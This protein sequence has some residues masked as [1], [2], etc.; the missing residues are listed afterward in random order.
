MVD[1]I[2]DDNAFIEISKYCEKL[3]LTVPTYISKELNEQYIEPITDETRQM[4]V[5]FDLVTSLV[6]EI[7]TNG[8]I[9]KDAENHLTVE[10]LDKEGH[11]VESTMDVVFILQDKDSEDGPGLMLF[12]FTKEEV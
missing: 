2:E 7:Q 12:V 8:G 4:E 1:V 5:V 3:G 6:K 10:L 11:N 9:E